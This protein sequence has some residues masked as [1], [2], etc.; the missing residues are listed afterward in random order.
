MLQSLAQFIERKTIPISLSIYFFWYLSLF[1]GR[2]SGDTKQAILLIKNG[3]STDWWTGTYFQ[4]LRLTTFDGNALYLASAITLGILFFAIIFF[5]R[6]LPINP[7]LHKYLIPIILIS[8]LAGGFGVNVSHDIFQATSILFV[9]AIEFK[10]LEKKF[11]S[12]KQD[13]LVEI[14]LVLTIMMTHFGIILAIFHIIQIARA[15]KIS[16]ALFV[17][18]SIIGAYFVGTVGVEASQFK[19]LRFPLIQDIKCIVQHPD[20]K[21]SAAN[22]ES[23]SKI[24]PLS[25]W[26]QK[27]ICRDQVNLLG[28]LPNLDA[29]G[30]SF[31]ELFKLYIEISSENPYLLV[32]QHIIR[33]TIVLPPPFFQSPDNQILYDREKWLGFDSNSELQNGPELIHPSLDIPELKVNIQIIKP[34]EFLALFPVFVINQASWFWSWSGFWIY[35]YI[36]FLIIIR[37]RNRRKYWS[38]LY[39]YALLSLFLFLLSPQSSGRYV[40]GNILIGFISLNYLFIVSA[41]YIRDHY[42][43]KK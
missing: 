39:P 23:L 22:W 10:I 17:S 25:E 8:P 32:Y 20:S 35:P 2:V 1:P 24:A 34:F 28:A 29:W 36:I 3:Q 30:L 37:I 33:S 43:V 14:L 9:T 41:A 40:M 11:L 21:V 5:I 12:N 4:F 31:Q 26:K 27:V 15:K 6:S 19:S 16:L 38:S 7:R 42:P 13:Y 18:V